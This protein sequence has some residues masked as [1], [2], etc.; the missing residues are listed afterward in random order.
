MNMSLEKSDAMFDSFEKWVK[1]STQ[2]D[3]VKKWADRLI[4]LGASWTSFCRAE[5]DVVADLVTGG[6]PLLAAR[7]I[8][9]LAAEAVKQTSAPMA[10]FWDLENLSILHLPPVATWQVD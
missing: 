8:V 6:I 9:K 10:I 7:N 2:K 4:D 5:D 3:C 1:S